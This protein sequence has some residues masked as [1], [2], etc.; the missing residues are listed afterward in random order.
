VFVA[1]RNSSVDYHP[2]YVSLDDVTLLCRFTG[3]LVF[4]LSVELP[5]KLRL[6]CFEIFGRGR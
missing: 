1:T 6:T 4:R 3:W 5:I 2:E